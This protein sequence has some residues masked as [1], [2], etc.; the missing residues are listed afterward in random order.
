MSLRSLLETF[1]PSPASAPAPS[2]VSVETAPSVDPAALR[3]EGYEAGYASGWEDARTA[4]DAA[5]QRVAAEFERNIEALAFTYHEAVDLVRAEL[6]DFVDAVVAAF[7]PAALPDLTR[8]HLRSA[9]NDLGEQAL[10]KP[11]EIVVSSDCRHSVEAMLDEDFSLDLTLVEDPGLAPHQI[12]LR[13]AE[14]ETSIDL[15]PLVD[16]LKDQLDAVKSASL[17]KEASDARA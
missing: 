11:V 8:E 3:S 12:F 7:L 13:L 17:P 1:D 14:T 4:D 9:L 16:T 15:M 5:R 6:M 2:P 10:V